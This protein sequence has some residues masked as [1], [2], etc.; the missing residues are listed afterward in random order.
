MPFIKIAGLSEN[1]VCEISK[2]LIDIVNKET[3]TPKERIRI[4]YNPMREIVDKKFSEDRV[5][6]DIEWMP[7]PLE[8]RKKVADNFFEYLENKGYKKVKIYFKDINKDY[9]FIK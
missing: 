5:L 9:Y 1:T 2:D 8:M 6:V 4:F 3:D 7:R